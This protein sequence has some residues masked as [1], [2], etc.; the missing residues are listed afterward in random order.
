[1]AGEYDSILP[2]LG[3]QDGVR[4][5]VV[6]KE[7]PKAIWNWEWIS[8]PHPFGINTATG[9]NRYFKFN[10]QIPFANAVGS[11]YIDGNVLVLSSINQLIEEFECS[12]KVIGLFR[13]CARSTLRE[14]LRACQI[15]GKISQEDG[16]HFIELLRGLDLE[17]LLDQKILTENSII[18]RRHCDHTVEIG[19]NLWRFFQSGFRRDQLCLPVV[20]NLLG[21]DCHTWNWNF[22]DQNDYFSIPTDHRSSKSFTSDTIFGLRVLLWKVRSG[23]IALRDIWALLVS[24]GIV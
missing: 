7:K 13:H 5:Y 8:P 21:N 4:F 3:K 9:Y 6:S 14:E 2:V 23:D 12:G 22:R 18:F 17:F 16:F 11:V 10:P 1:M 24:R 15:K 19:D 20:L